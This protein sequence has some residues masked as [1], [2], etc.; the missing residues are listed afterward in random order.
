[1]QR[2]A[3]HIQPAQKDNNRDK[4]QPFGC[5]PE[6]YKTKNTDKQTDASIRNTV[7]NMITEPENVIRIEE[8][9]YLQNGTGKQ[10]RCIRYLHIY[11]SSMA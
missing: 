1:M 3:Q 7:I 4:L 5:T 11:D 8:H 6:K 2:F 10:F 9:G